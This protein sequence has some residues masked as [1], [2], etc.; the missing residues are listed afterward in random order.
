MNCQ[1]AS[2]FSTR[3]VHAGERSAPG[4]WTPVASAIHP[5]VGYTYDDMDELDKVFAGE[6]AGY[7]YGRFGSPT[8]AALEAAVAE[9]EQGAGAQAYGSGMAAI[10]GA[11]LACGARAGAHLVAAS[12]LYGATRS[13]IT[14]LLGAQGVTCEYVDVLKLDA[15]AQALGQSACS[16]LVVE[17]VSNPL[18]HVADLE[19]LAVIAHR[20]GAALIVDNTFATPYLCNPLA[21]G[22]DVV[23]HS[24]TK[25]LGGHGDVTAGVAVASAE[26]RRL[27]NE[28]N[29]LAGGV[30]GPFEAWLVLRGLKT[31][32]L[33]MRQQCAS[34][35]RVAGWLGSQ[36]GVREVLYPGTAAADQRALAARLFGDKGFG[37]IVSF[38]LDN[39]GRK[40]AFR[41]MSALRLCQAATSLGDVY[42]LVLH[43]ATS[44]HRGLDQAERDR[45]GITDDLVRLSVG[46]EDAEDII[47]DLQ[48]A[49]RAV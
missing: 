47:A 13:L 37:G 32:A 35:A 40:A 20:H 12:E 45:L 44:S 26:R 3:A 25:Y 8:V 27:L 48:Q 42:S 28:T 24:A 4:K 1:E 5:S 22:A 7:V 41:F 23:V 38:R 9:L 19:A 14:G 33:R 29:R 36:G 31:L 6:E 43:P 34:A 11:L 39:G 10:H 49:L 18:L 46:I 2:G 15:V 21:L 16:A 17:T 30:L